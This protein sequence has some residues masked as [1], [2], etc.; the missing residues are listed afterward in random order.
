MDKHIFITKSNVISDPLLILIGLCR[1]GLIYFKC[2]KKRFTLHILLRH[3]NTQIFYV[4]LELTHIILIILQ[5]IRQTLLLRKKNC[6][7]NNS[8][9]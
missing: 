9:F 7:G 8:Y 3:T 5:L 2:K 4:I 6:N 1:L